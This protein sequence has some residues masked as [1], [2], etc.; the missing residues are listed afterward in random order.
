[1]IEQNPENKKLFCYS[2]E[3]LDNIATY[4]NNKAFNEILMKKNLTFEQFINVLLDII[5]EFAPKTFTIKCDYCNNKI[6]NISRIP[7]GW[8]NGRMRKVPYKIAPLDTTEYICTPTLCSF[9]VEEVKK[10]VNT[11][12]KNE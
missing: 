8:L 9:H 2:Y 6:E 3:L 10:L 12:S 7:E 1:M 11:I 4:K 5:N